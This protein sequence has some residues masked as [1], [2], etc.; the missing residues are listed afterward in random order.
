MEQRL[1]GLLIGLLMGFGVGWYA[2]SREVY[3]RDHIQAKAG[4]FI[5]GYANNKIYTITPKE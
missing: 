1:I 2:G 5:D 4:I 3:H